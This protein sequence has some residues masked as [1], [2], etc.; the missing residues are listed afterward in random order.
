LI[1][2]LK[3]NRGELAEQYRLETTE[4]LA[5]ILVNQELQRLRAQEDEK[6]RSRL[7]S[8][9]VREPLRHVTGRY[10]RVELKGN[11]LV[12]SDPYNEFPLAEISTGAQEQVLLAL[13]IAFASMIM[14]RQKAFLI[15]DDAFQHAD[16]QRR[17]YLLEEIVGLA[18]A[19]WQIL[20]FT[21]DDHIRDLFDEVGKETF[22]DQYYFAELPGGNA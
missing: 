17:G 8:E 20:Y 1:Q 4:A 19:G 18:Q 15:L 22:G 21:M 9:A 3:E 5:K 12:V 6:I 2:S 10:E 16:W 14:E 13:R 7:R 11:Q